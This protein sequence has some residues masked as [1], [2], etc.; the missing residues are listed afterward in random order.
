MPS[1]FQ[2]G[3]PTVKRIIGLMTLGILTLVVSALPAAEEEQNAKEHY[4]ATIAAVGGPAGGSTASIDIWIDKF[5]TDEEALSLAA[6][7]AEKGRDA[8]RL[9][10]EKLDAGRISID[11]RNIVPIAVARSLA[12]G[13]DRIIRLII[14]R[15][16]LFL[17]RYRLTRSQD[18]PFTIIELQVDEKGQGQGA[19]ILSAQ[20][21][22]DDKNK[23]FVVK[24]LGQGTNLK[25]VN[26]RKF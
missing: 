10:M 22:F 6:L 11:H 2:K 3:V 7:L 26:V 20:I 13:K 9:A 12:N 5:S 8:L 23:Q 1:C 21:R 24:S 17:E 15:N 4:A 25:L 16:I 18:Y 14:A 19:A